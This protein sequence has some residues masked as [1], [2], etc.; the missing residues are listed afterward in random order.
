MHLSATMKRFL[1]SLVALGLL[2]ASPR[3][4]A[5]CRWFG[6]QFECELAGRQLAIGTQVASEP[7]RVGAVRAQ[8]FSGGTDLLDDGRVAGPLRLELQNVGTDAG[9]C[10][11]FGD[12]TYCH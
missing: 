10:W 8:P 2:S 1:C 12:E 6:T 5:S 4:W 11:K 7:S 3:A 9:L